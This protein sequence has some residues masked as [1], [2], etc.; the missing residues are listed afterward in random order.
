VLKFEHVNVT[1]EAVENGNSPIGEIDTSDFAID[2]INVPQNFAYRIDDVREIQV[3]RRYLMQQ[4]GE[5]EKIILADDGDFKFGITALLELKGGIDTAKSP[6]KD[7]YTRLFHSDLIF[8]SVFRAA[9][10]LLEQ[11][12]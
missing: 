8:N 1:I 6:A 9:S 12:A 4:R 11:T 2:E 7:H 10:S 5:Q 3:A